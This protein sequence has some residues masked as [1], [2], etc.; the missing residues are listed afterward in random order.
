MERDICGENPELATSLYVGRS[1]LDAYGLLEFRD[2]LK[3]LV[4]HMFEKL[5]GVPCGKEGKRM[6]APYAG[7]CC[8][9]FSCH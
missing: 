3:T 9:Q 6:A 7:L 5:H 2:T 1:V 4:E 8:G